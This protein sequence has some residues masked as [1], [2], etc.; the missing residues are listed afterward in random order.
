MKTNKIFALNL[1][2]EYICQNFT[3]EI[4]GLLPFVDFLFANEQEIKCFARQIIEH[5]N[6]DTVSMAKE[7]RKLLTKNSDTCLIVTQGAKP[8]ILISSKLTKKTNISMI[9]FI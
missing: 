5:S 7:I 1:S 2:A 8:V 6:E 4:L 9:L 3:E